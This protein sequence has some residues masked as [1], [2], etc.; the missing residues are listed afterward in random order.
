MFARIGVMRAMNRHGE[1][2]FSPEPQG[3]S[4][5]GRKLAHCALAGVE[6]MGFGKSPLRMRKNI[7]SVLAGNPIENLRRRHRLLRRMWIQGSGNRAPAVADH[8]LG[9][10]PRLGFVLEFAGCA[11]RPA[12]PIAL[13][14]DIRPIGNVPNIVICRAHP[15]ASRAVASGDDCPRSTSRAFALRLP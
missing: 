6:F 11:N 7:C 3:S 4:L 14:R 13:G 9:K 2:V 5:G 1:R 10:L 15:N 8:L 12:L